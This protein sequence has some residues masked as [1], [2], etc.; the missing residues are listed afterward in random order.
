M[1]PETRLPELAS[2]VLTGPAHYTW[3]L[4]PDLHSMS[5]KQQL[6]G[7]W[8]VG[9]TSWSIYPCNWSEVRRRR[10]LVA[11][12]PFSAR[13]RRLW[14]QILHTLCF[15]VARCWSSTVPWYQ[16]LGNWD[17]KSHLHLLRTGSSISK[18]S[19]SMLCLY[20][21]PIFL[22]WRNRNILFEARISEAVPLGD[23]GPKRWKLESQRS[24]R[25]YWLIPIDFY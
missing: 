19:H 12:R 7:D 11:R 4:P 5:R 24:I 25:A 9:W 6:C 3:P 8:M 13:N 10:R 22:S 18:Y 21:K 1:R 14:I 2:L 16:S 17:R 20:S 15:W 23:P